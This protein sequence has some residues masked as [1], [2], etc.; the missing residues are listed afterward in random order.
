[1]AEIV[2][3]HV[4]IFTSMHLICLHRTYIYGSCMLQS[5]PLFEPI[6]IL[7]LPRQ[8]LV[9]F[10]SYS[11]M[12]NH[13]LDLNVGSHYKI[14]KN[15]TESQVTIYVAFRCYHYASNN[16]LCYKTLTRKQFHSKNIKV[17][18]GKQRPVCI[19]LSVQ[20]ICLMVN[21]LTQN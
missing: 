10:F 7:I 17:G 13:L 1:M 12:L 20:P 8:D 21:Y 5:A 11:K 2:T 6:Y 16:H 9:L 19:S 15:I 3:L 4:I 18:V 14:N